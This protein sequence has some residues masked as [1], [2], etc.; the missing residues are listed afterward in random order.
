[1]TKYHPVHFKKTYLQKMSRWETSPLH[2]EKVSKMVWQHFQEEGAHQKVP[3][4]LGATS[5]TFR[6]ELLEAK[7]LGAVSPIHNNDK[8]ENLA[9]Q[10]QDAK[11]TYG[12]IAPLWAGL[13]SLSETMEILHS[14]GML[15]HDA[16]KENLLLLEENKI[17]S[18]YL[19]DF[20]TTEEDERFGT[21]SWER[22]CREDRSHL[23]EEAALIA[24]CKNPQ[25]KIPQTS[26]LAKEVGNLL[27]CSPK[28]LSVQKILKERADIN[29]PSI[30]Q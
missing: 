12:A 8:P 1:M 20:E 28:L 26:Q 13:E 24:L 29:G 23:I 19:I 17:L 27:A 11:K 3:L 30:G 22:A 7:S 10:I 15:H 21:S 25:E 6:S 2:E 4:P 16:H 18:G 5:S 14:G 9:S